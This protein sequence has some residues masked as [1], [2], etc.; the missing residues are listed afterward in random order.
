MVGAA[1]G[2]IVAVERLVG[3]PAQSP[4]IAR[5]KMRWTVTDLVPH[6]SPNKSRA[7]FCS[8]VNAAWESGAI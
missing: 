8:S 6:L 3:M 2:I 4:I 5:E 1:V 7:L